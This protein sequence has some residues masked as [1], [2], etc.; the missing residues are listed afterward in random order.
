MMD[1]EARMVREPGLD[2]GM[3]VG[4]AIVGDQVYQNDA[5]IVERRSSRLHYRPVISHAASEAP[6]DCFVS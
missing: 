5:A 1:V 2:L 3:F 4:G 6:C